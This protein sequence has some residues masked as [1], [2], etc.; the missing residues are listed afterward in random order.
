[1][2]EPKESICMSPCNWCSKSKNDSCMKHEQNSGKSGY[3]LES[4][5][6]EFRESMRWPEVIPKDACQVIRCLCANV[7]KVDGVSDDV[8]NGEEK[9]YE[10]HVL[11]KGDE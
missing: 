9:R 2:S 5:V 6:M 1:M 11:V 10:R 4:P 3:R 8:K 7:V